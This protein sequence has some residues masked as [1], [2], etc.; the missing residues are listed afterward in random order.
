ME[1]LNCKVTFSNFK[2]TELNRKCFPINFAKF[3]QTAT[4]KI[5]CKRLLLN[6]GI[7]SKT[8]TEGKRG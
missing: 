8:R 6:E 7:T 5:T 1:F 4:L 2:E 3:F